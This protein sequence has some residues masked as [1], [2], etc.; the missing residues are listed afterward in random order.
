VSNSVSPCVT[1]PRPTSRITFYGT[2]LDSPHVTFC[3]VTL[4]T[5]NTPMPR[6]TN[7][8]LSLSM[9]HGIPQQA[10]HDRPSWNIKPSP[11]RSSPVHATAAS[12]PAHVSSLLETTDLPNAFNAPIHLLRNH[13]MNQMEKSRHR[14][15]EHCHSTWMMPR[16]IPTSPTILVT[17]VDDVASHSLCFPYSES[18]TRRQWTHHWTIA[19][20]CRS[21]SPKCRPPTTPLYKMGW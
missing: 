16:G 15:I 1:F 11:H 19:A 4:Y 9:Q 17:D 8:C 7:R 21:P 13:Y 12:W 20:A 14:L 6:I 10:P 5:W 18:T 3:H 2:Q